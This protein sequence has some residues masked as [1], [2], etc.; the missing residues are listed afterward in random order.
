MSTVIFRQPEQHMSVIQN[1]SVLIGFLGKKR[2]P[3]ISAPADEGRRRIF[4]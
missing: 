3:E 4:E 2:K 1:H